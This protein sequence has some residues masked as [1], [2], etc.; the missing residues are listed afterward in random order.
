M[1]N[2]RH[3]LFLNIIF[4]NVSSYQVALGWRSVQGKGLRPGSEG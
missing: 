2:V 3:N 4:G 1:A